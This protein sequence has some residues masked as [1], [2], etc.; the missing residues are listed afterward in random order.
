MEELG[1]LATIV[2]AV[3]VVL[4][5]LD[6]NPFKSDKTHYPSRNNTD[7]GS[8]KQETITHVPKLLPKQTTSFLTFNVEGVSFKMIRVEGGTFMM[9]A[10]NSKNNEYPPHQVTLS[11]YYIGETVVTQDLWRAV[12]KT[13]IKDPAVFEGANLPVENVSWDDCQVF[14]KKLNA[15]K[16]K[17]FRLPTEA[18]WE[19]AA[20]GGINNRN[21]FK[22]S[23]SNILEKVAWYCENSYNKTHVVAQ[24]DPNE[25]GVY[26]MSGNVWDWCHDKYEE[27]SGRPQKD[28]RGPMKGK[29]HVMRGGSWHAYARSCRV[30]HRDKDFHT[31]KDSDLG[32]RLAL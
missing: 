9:G 22:F 11:T 26:D 31:Y 8:R 18:E 7:L 29:E 2:A 10:D 17:N 1:I 32:F 24:K 27:Y 30:S 16:G 23:G 3:V 6:I 19:F 28:P 5:Y 12:M 4:T 15:T 25:L 21:G 20:R 14:I 13:D